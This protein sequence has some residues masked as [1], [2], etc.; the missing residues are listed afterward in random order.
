MIQIT[1]TAFIFYK[2]KLLLIFH[3]KMQKW[4]HVGGHVENNEL[5]DE[6]LKREIKEE[7]GLDIDIIDAYPQTRFFSNEKL[8]IPFFVQGSQK[9]NKK[10]ISIDYVCEVKGNSKVT[11]Q[12]EEL[13]N[14]KWIKESEIDSID[15]FPLLKQLAKE[16]FR[17]Y[18][19]NQKR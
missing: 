19:L 14:Y 16:A 4:M 11:L 17:I 5:F 15:T 10:Q 18:R 2:N 3:K 6:T 1:T 13:E 8:A 12:K 9:N 7:V